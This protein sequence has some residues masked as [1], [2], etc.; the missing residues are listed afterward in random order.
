MS[1]KCI[2]TVESNQ[3]IEIICSPRNGPFVDRS[4]AEG[5]VL[6]HTKDFP[7]SKYRIYRLEEIVEEEPVGRT[8]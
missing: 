2:V 6:Q 7:E 3:G 1:S 8:N 4:K 5:F